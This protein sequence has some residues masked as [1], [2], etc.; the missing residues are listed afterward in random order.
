MIP[1]FVRQ[2][3][4]GTAEERGVAGEEKLRAADTVP[5]GILRD[6]RLHARAQ[7]GV[8]LEH[9]PVRAYAGELS[10]GD[11]AFPEDRA[12]ARRGDARGTLEQQRVDLGSEAA[13][14]LRFERPGDGAAARS[15]ETEG[16]H[17]RA[18]DGERGNILPALCRE[19]PLAR[20]KEKRFTQQPPIVC[21]GDHLFRRVVA[22]HAGRLVHDG[23]RRAAQHAA[24]A[25][26][27]QIDERFAAHRHR[28]G[29][30]GNVAR[31][32]MAA[33]VCAGA[34][35]K[36]DEI[37]VARSVARGHAAEH[38]AD[39]VVDEP[40]AA[41]TGRAERAHRRFDALAHE[42]SLRAGDA[43]FLAHA[44]DPTVAVRQAL[45]RER[46]RDA[47]ALRLP[48]DRERKLCDV[49]EHFL[50][51][52]VLAERAGHAALL[53]RFR[54]GLSR[55]V[56]ADAAGAEIRAAGVEHENA[57]ARA[58]R[59]RRGKKRRQ[60]HE[61]GG[62]AAQSRAHVGNVGVRQRLKRLLLIEHVVTPEKFFGGFFCTHGGHSP[63]P[64]A[65]TPRPG[66]IVF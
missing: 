61:R 59:A 42:L 4:P 9:R 12:Q 62:F 18:R 28:F 37:G 55:F 24:E 31:L 34:E 5:G 17:H 54:D 47:R 51:V 6:Q 20:G 64:G 8:E 21:P 33:G 32:H 35:N 7:H 22:G 15:V 53:Q 23:V 65:L 11:I 38:G 13:V 41:L 19:K 48:R 27:F 36:A 10:G 3:G 46:E 60:H 57:L 26:G 45:A 56:K 39:G 58:R 50:R 30:F 16:V 63:C 29:R 2:R 52:R 1:F 66:C 43:R 44:D 40:P 14:V 49:A 25:A